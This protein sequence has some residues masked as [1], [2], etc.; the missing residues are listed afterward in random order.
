[1][2]HSV[3]LVL[4]PLP[5]QWPAARRRDFYRA[6]AEQGP[7]DRVVLGETVCSKRETPV[8]EAMAEAEVALKAAGREVVRPTITLAVDEEDVRVL[9]AVSKTANAG[10][11]I[12]AN[13]TGALAL[14]SGK[15]HHIG[16]MVNVYNEGTLRALA[17]R[18]ATA[19]TLPWELPRRSVEVLAAEA[20]RLG[21]ECGLNVFG[22]A[23]LAISARCYHARAHGLTKATC[24]LICDQDPEG[25]EVDTLE[26]DE[27]LIVNGLQTQARTVT[28]LVR[29]IPDLIKAG[30]TAIRLAPLDLD[31]VAAGQVYADLI[32]GACSVDAAEDRL[33]DLLE[34]RA[35]ANGFL[36]A[37]PGANWVAAE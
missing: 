4:G 36:H 5:Y 37:E 21:V 2:T 17:G 27:F 35:V 24:R 31:M 34:D 3:K 30:V 18:G 8:A 1:M 6:I 32:A 26:G 19:V 33:L 28:L 16:P 15:P 14:L 22:R 20:G 9:E 25:L 13:D 7:Y 10:A 23:P 29:E 11:L 12:E